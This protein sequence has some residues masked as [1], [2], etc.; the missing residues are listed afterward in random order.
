MSN[1]LKNGIDYYL[2]NGKWVF[3]SKYLLDRGYCCNN[4]CRHC[5]YRL[6]DT[7]SESVKKG[8]VADEKSSSES[9]GS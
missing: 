3:T 5:P 4:N 9:V 1:K 8:H 2:E 7:S 6:V